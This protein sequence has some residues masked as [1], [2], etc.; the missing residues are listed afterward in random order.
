MSETQLPQLAGPRRR[1]AALAGEAPAR[2][3]PG[4]I[5]VATLGGVA[6]LVLLAA[7]GTLLDQTV[8]IPPLAASAA[9]VFAAPALPLAQPRNVIGGQLVSTLVGFLAL[10]VAGSSVWASAVAGGLAIGAMALTRTSHSPAAATAVI[11]VVTDPS[12]A[13]FLPLLLLATLVIVG[14]GILAGRTGKTVR[15]PAYWW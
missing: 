9:L 14:V 12:A 7:I 6:A 8:L 1:T 3:A 15:Y 5:S 2:P 10:A 13:L 11:V 4:F